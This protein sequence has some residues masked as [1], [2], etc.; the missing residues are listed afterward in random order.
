MVALDDGELVD[1]QP[2]VVGGVV[3][4]EDLGV[5]AADAPVG[6]PILDGHAVH[7]RLVEGS[8]AGVEGGAGGAG[9]L[10]EG[11]GAHGSRQIGIEAGES[12]AE[13]GREGHIGVAR[14]FRCGPAGSKIGAVSG[15]PARLAE[16]LHRGL[17]NF[18]FCD[19]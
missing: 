2:V 7:Q 19:M 10:A 16:P 15:G 3:E 6:R 8:V 5:V 14:A 13:A 1:G 12:V 4:V 9:Q 18:G 11:V 17:L